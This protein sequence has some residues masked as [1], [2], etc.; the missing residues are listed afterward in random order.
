MEMEKPYS[1]AKDFWEERRSQY[2]EDGSA[3]IFHEDGGFSLVEA[4][5]T[6]EVG[7]PTKSTK[8]R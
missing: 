5:A 2:Y 8:V 4:I 1:N 3:I 7:K 6:Y